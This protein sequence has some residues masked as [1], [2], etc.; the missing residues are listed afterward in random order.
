MKMETMGQDYGF[1]RVNDNIS[2]SNGSGLKKYNTYWM[3][4]LK[5]CWKNK[6]N[7]VEIHH[8]ADLGV[9]VVLLGGVTLQEYLLGHG[10]SL[11]DKHP[12]MHS[13]LGAGF[14]L[15]LDACFW[16]VGRNWNTREKP[17]WAWWEHANSKQ[18]GPILNETQKV[19]T[20]A[21]PCCSSMEFFLSDHF[22]ANSNVI[23]HT[24]EASAIFT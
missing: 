5:W 20:T 3:S 14:Q 22:R 2:Q 24:S 7:Q 11:Q 23:A 8:F 15:A 12:Q 4:L 18:K 16:T 9:G 17:T 10:F 6:S 21:P 13:Y 19:V 1:T